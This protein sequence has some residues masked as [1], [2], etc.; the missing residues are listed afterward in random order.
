MKKFL[1]TLMAAIT[2]TATASAATYTSADI[3]AAGADILTPDDTITIT[4]GHIVCTERTGNRS[5]YI[6]AADGLFFSLR[7]RS[8]LYQTSD[9]INVTA[10][11]Y[12]VEDNLI[13]FDTTLIPAEI[14]ISQ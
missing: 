2:L 4:N 8:A 14:T 5:I 6:V 3:A 12:A 10:P 13:Y 7:D 11:F 9:H 1:C